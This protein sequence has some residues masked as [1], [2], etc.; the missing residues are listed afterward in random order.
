[1]RLLLRDQIREDKAAVLLDNAVLDL[2]TYVTWLIVLES[3]E[4]VAVVG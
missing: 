3:S 1:M 4:L 2:I